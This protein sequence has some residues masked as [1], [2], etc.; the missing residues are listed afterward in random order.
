MMITET[1]IDIYNIICI[2]DP[3]HTTPGAAGKRLEAGGGTHPQSERAREAVGVHDA[4]DQ[5]PPPTHYRGASLMRNTPPSHGR[6]RVLWWSYGGGAVSYE[7][8]TPVLQ[9]PPGIDSKQVVT[10]ILEKYQVEIG[11][12]LG[13]LQGLLLVLDYS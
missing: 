8:G 7:R 13:E 3:A 6:P 2:Y 12:G 5:H 9:V 1:F 11:N 4:T 10:Y